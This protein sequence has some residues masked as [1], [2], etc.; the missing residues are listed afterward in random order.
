VNST[1]EISDPLDRLK[2]RL[3]SRPQLYRGLITLLSPVVP[4]PG[5]IRRFLRETPGLVLNLGSGNSRLG[6]GV[7]NVDLFDY[8]QVDVV[9]D[10]HALPFADGSV[11][12]VISIA[13]LEHVADPAAV[14]REI[15]RVLKP[16][17]RVFSLIPFMQPFHASPFDF[18]RYTL[19]GIR[20]LHRDFR[21]IDSGVAGGP[22]SGFLWV[23]QEM[24][25][26][27]FSFGMA[28]LHHLLLIL[29]MLLTWPLKFLDLLLA[30]LPTAVHLASSFYV[31]ATKPPAPAE[32]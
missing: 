23:A 26:T 21:E 4:S 22:V 2:R 8:D 9:A 17:G 31:H 6:A 18:Q 12:G 3:K 1:A 20:H 30:R 11:D 19:P 27:L 28:R 13:V 25:A 14:L 7:V 32:P 24:F 15:R 16:G 29:A 10:I 5:P